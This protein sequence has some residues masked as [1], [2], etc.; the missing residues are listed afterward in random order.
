MGRRKDPLEKAL[1]LFATHAES[2]GLDFNVEAMRQDEHEVVVKENE[3]DAVL[4]SLHK[5]HKMMIKKCQWCQEAFATNYCFVSYCCHS[6][7]KKALAELGIEWSHNGQPVWGRH[8]PPAIITPKVLKT[9]EAWARW[10][11]TN[12]DQMSNQVLEELLAYEDVEASCED[13][14]E[15]EVPRNPSE[16]SNGEAQAN[17]QELL[18]DLDFEDVLSFEL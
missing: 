3:T 9:L 2:R 14:P 10:L 18:L 8:E 16:E 5:P 15:Q 6:H 12:L 4:L 1:A 7:R 11:T 13:Q 17:P